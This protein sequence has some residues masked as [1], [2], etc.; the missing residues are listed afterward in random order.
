MWWRE[1]DLNWW[2]TAFQAA[3]LPTELPR[4]DEVH[5]RDEVPKSKSK[6]KKSIIAPYISYFILFKWDRLSNTESYSGWFFLVRLSTRFARDF[7]AIVEIARHTRATTC[8]A[9]P[10]DL[11]RSNF[12]RRKSTPLSPVVV[13]FIFSAKRTKN[14]AKAILS[15]IFGNISLSLWKMNSK[16][17]IFSAP[18][19]DNFSIVRWY[20]QLSSSPHFGVKISK[21]FE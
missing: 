6:N 11:S 5:Y 2:H 16:P 18:L 21:W 13:I 9:L 10:A 12:N 14:S 1:P 20:N 15:W 8:L 4:Q 3:A 19:S 17:P 7:W